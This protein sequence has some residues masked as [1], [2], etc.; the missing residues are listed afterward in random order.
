MLQPSPGEVAVRKAIAA[1]WRGA[2][3]KPDKNIDR[4]DLHP[5]RQDLGAAT[6]ALTNNEWKAATV[7]AGAT[8]SSLAL[9]PKAN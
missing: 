1:P 6:R 9:A 2:I 5:I 4:W 8:R 3:G 7:L